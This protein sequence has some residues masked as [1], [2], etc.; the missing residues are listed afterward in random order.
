MKETVIAPSDCPYSLKGCLLTSVEVEKRSCRLIF[1]EGIHKG[2][3]ITDGY[4]A[5]S[6]LYRDSFMM[7]HGK[8]KSLKSV[9][10]LDLRVNALSIG[11]QYA[12]LIGDD[13][14]LVLHYGGQII[15]HTTY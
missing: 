4:V 10:H 7:I 14:M 6:E 2:D 15:F 5:V 9:H 11:D 12:C 13:E 1:M 3:Q 8:K